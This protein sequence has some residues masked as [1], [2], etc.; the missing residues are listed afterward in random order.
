MPK[1]SHGSLRSRIIP[2]DSYDLLLMLLLAAGSLILFMWGL[3]SYELHDPWEPKYPQTVAQMI[4]R[5]DLLTPYYVDEN[6]WTKPILHYWTIYIG[7]QLVGNNELAARLPSVFAATWGVLVVFHLLRRISNRWTALMGGVILATLPQYFLM[8]RQATPDMLMVSLLTTSLAALALYTVGGDEDRGRRR[9]LVLFYIFMGLAALTKGPLALAIP[10]GVLTLFHLSTLHSTLLQREIA[11]LPRSILGTPTLDG[12]RRVV[13]LIIEIIR[14]YRPLLGL[15][16]LFSILAPWITTMLLKHGHEYYEYAIN[17][18]NLLRFKQVFRDHHG[19]SL[20]YLRTL[21]Y[22]M[23]PWSGL[24]PLFLLLIVRDPSPFPL[25]QRL[26]FLAWFGAIFLIMTSAGTKLQHYL[27]PI[28]PAAAILLALFWRH[29]LWEKTSPRTLLVML[30]GMLFLWWGVRDYLIEDLGLVFDS[31]RPNH[32]TPVHM[33]AQVHDFLEILL[34]AWSL[35]MALGILL[36][37][38]RLVAVL[39]VCIA[40]ANAHVFSHR[41]LPHHALRYSIRSHILQF[42]QDREHYTELVYFGTLRPSTRYY[43]RYYEPQPGRHR[44]DISRYFGKKEKESFLNHIR[45]RNDLFVLT[46]NSHA[47][48]IVETL[49][50]QTGQTWKIDVKL[51]SIHVRLIPPSDTGQEPHEQR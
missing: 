2:V 21:F 8:A 27:L 41:I 3:S 5:D 18:E 46:R 43:L 28:M 11:P 14:H 47:S 19:T 20:Y 17:Y 40:V 36:A 6:R 49:Q 15:L 45:D 13:L 1:P 50:R 34:P 42:E 26:F 33:K 29:Y 23:L 10:V 24:L 31:F 12:V 25:K 7:V 22:G 4:E 32:R 30:T 44:I 35:V 9:W 39:A 48:E 16:I 38:S 51:P 37:R